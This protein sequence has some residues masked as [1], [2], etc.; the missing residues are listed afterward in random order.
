MDTL[1]VAGG[2]YWQC[3]YDVSVDNYNSSFSAS[4]YDTEDWFASCFSPYNCSV[5]DLLPTFNITAANTTENDL[6]M[7]TYSFLQN[8]SYYDNTTYYYMSVLNTSYTLNTT[9][10][11]LMQC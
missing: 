8:V 5:W 7:T 4:D 9:E 10:A 2:K 3:Q 11:D 1:Q 6:M